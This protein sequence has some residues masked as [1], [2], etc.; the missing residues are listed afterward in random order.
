MALQEDFE[1]QGN[2]LFKNRGTI[3]LIIVIAGISVFLR[4]ELHPENYWLKNES[5]RHYYTW[6]CLLISMIGLGIRVFTVGYTPANTSG[7][8]TASQLADELNTTGIYSVVRHPLYLG[9]FFMWLGPVMLTGQLWFVAVVCLFYWVY[10]ERI[11]FAEE[12][13]L[14]RKF[15]EIYT[16][17]AGKVPAFIPE[18]HKYVKPGLAFSWKKVLKKEKNGLV[19]VFAIFCVMDSLGVYIRKDSNY[20]FVL[21]ACCLLTVILYFVLKYLKYKTTLLNEEGR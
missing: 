2:W 6:L 12:Q 3:P 8:N 5:F 13:F 15:G 10:Y 7:R 4:T 20:D 16:S 19:N 14:R 1:E 9:N 17:W 18:W 11:M 21:I